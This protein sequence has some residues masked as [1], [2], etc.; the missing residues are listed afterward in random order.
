MP[1]FVPAARQ[2]WSGLT[3]VA[4][5]ISQFACAVELAMQVRNERRALMRMD[6][7]ALQDVGFDSGKAYGEAN[8]SFWDV[9]V[10]RLRC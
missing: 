6:E 5:R 8:R 9:P 1:S 4:R 7:R 10:D 2:P 3:Q